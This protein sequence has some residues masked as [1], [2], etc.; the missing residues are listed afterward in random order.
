MPFSPSLLYQVNPR[1]S[2][3]LLRNSRN[4]LF[5]NTTEAQRFKEYV[6]KTGLEFTNEWADDNIPFLS[7]LLASSLGQ[8]PSIN[9]LEIGVY[10]G[11]MMSFMHFTFGDR[12]K[13]TALDPWSEPTVNADSRYVDIERRFLRNVERIGRPVEV[14]KGVSWQLLPE[15]V[16]SGRTFDLVYLDGNHLAWAVYL[17]MCFCL[18]LLQPGGILIIDDYWRVRQH[19]HRCVKQA[20]DEIFSAFREHLTVVSVYR[21]VV[22]RLDR[23]IPTNPSLSA[24]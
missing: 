15:M 18:S 8:R 22:L 20:V 24:V 2:F 21:Q 7:P 6:A 12:I 17:D 19:G 14:K 10:E 16:Q 9:Y 3:E 13:A 4:I 1:F 11:R 23:K 5:P